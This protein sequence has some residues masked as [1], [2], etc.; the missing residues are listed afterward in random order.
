MGLEWMARHPAVCA[1]RIGVT[2]GSRGGEL[3]LLL[4]SMLPAI[5]AIVAYVPSSVVWSGFGKGTYE[6][7]TAPAAWTLR[8]V[9]IPFMPPY[10]GEVNLDINEGDPIPLT[11]YFLK[12][13]E[14]REGI[15]RARI[16][17]ERIGGPVMLISGEADAMWPSAAFA[18]MAMDC[19]ERAGHSNAHV[20]LKYAGAGH[21]IHAP[22]GPT[23][24]TDTVHPVD[25]E[26]YA[27]GGTAEGGARANE[28]SWQQMLAFLNEHLSA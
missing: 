4:G 28:D 14:N 27:L 8:G 20:H 26:L 21:G 7:A 6:L 9:P 16:A 2:G 17:V 1:D 3:V 25:G 19:L 10:E 23:T 5:K 11:P 12:S 13:M 18:D 24:V 15:E 22:Y